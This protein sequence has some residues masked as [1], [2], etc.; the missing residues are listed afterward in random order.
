MKLTGKLNRKTPLTTEE[1]YYYDSIKE[2]EEVIGLIESMKANGYDVLSPYISYIQDHTDQ[3]P[4]DEFP[5]YESFKEALKK[6]K[7]KDVSIV[8][9]SSFDQDEEV[10]CS[11][12]LGGNVFNVSRPIKKN[13]EMKR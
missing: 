9:Y 12:N 3:R 11:I 5:T 8:G 7:I 4:R 6:T 2:T 1:Y 13:D 10:H